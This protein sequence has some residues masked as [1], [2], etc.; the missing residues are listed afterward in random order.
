ML[1][2]TFIGGLAD[3]FGRKNASLLFVALYSVSCATK[4]FPNYYTLM[5]G[6]FLGGIATSIMHSSFE[7]WM[8]HEHNAVSECCIRATDTVTA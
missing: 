5:L 2:G 6:R 8:I 4:H 7:S 3:K 1:F